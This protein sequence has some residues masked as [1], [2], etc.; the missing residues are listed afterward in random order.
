M[1]CDRIAPWALRQIVGHSRNTRVP[2]KAATMATRTRKATPEVPA[3]DE[4]AGEVAPV[5]PEIVVTPEEIAKVSAARAAHTAL[6]TANANVMSSL[7][8]LGASLARAFAS[9]AH[10]IMRDEYT[11]ADGQSLMAAYAQWAAPMVFDLAEV[12]ESGRKSKLGIRFT[13]VTS[14]PITSSPAR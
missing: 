2:R 11:Q 10:V 13:M 1:P 12:N 9:N 14:A 6:L 8:E 3:N 4:P 7:D 5:I